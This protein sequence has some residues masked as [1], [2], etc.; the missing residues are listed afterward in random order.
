MQ[1]FALINTVLA[2]SEG[3]P[4][5]ILLPLGLIIL[6]GK[7]FSLFM[8]KLKLPQVVGMLLAGLAVG[9]ILF[10][11]NQNI[12]TD[13]TLDGIGELSKIG[14]V[15]ILFT[16]GL[17]TDLKK[18]KELGKA[19]VVI[20]SLGVIVPLLFGFLLSWAFLDNGLAEPYTCIYYGV[21][22]TATSVSVG[23]ATLKELG[24]L[25]SK[26][27][28]AITSAAI[29]DDVIGVI[30][31]SV[32]IS[33][34]GK[35]SSGV[36]YS[37]NAGLNLF[38]MILV[39]AAFFAL[40]IVMGIF[41][42]KF[43]DWV[44]RKYPHHRRIPMLGLAFCFIWAYLAE[45]VFQVA[46][47]TG[48]YVAGLIIANSAAAKYIDHRADQIASI[49]FVP[50]FFASVGISM[51]TSLSGESSAAGIDVGIFVIFG[52]LWIVAGL[53]G[54]IVGC[55]IGGK[56]TGFNA[57]DSFKIGIGMMAR[58]EVLIVTAQKGIDAGL[59]SSFIMPFTVGL[60]VASSFLTPIILKAL[61]KNEPPEDGGE[62]ANR[63]P[64]QVEAPT[65]ATNA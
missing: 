19:S 7:L 25:D 11:P 8:G 43:F 42:H 38:L 53:A 13:Y 54:K 28:T 4:Y 26:V 44:G 18:I 62:L 40:S 50:V 36:V 17:E 16:A 60:I 34:S 9:L 59:V 12:L 37:D 64:P 63:E 31:L 65:N 20:T 1:H 23:V 35:G 10:I 58:A 41:F 27:G 55:F 48:A 3:S 15:L 6:L 45:A 46:D 39:M 51:Y 57:K 33:L 29:L 52:L 22:L 14:V 24:R 49:I 21:I 61:Y 32:V 2:D 47:I 5:M 56:I 30:L